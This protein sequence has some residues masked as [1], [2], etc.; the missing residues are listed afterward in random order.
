MAKRLR[1]RVW[2]ALMVLL[3]MPVSYAQQSF[4]FVALGDL[5]YGPIDVSHQ[6]LSAAFEV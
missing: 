6:H 4:S 5:P 2:L 3:S 1:A